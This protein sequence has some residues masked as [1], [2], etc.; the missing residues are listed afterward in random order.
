MVMGSMKTTQS[1]DTRA[2]SEQVLLGLLRR[3]SPAEKLS[4]VRSL[5]QMV[6]G[7]SRRAISRAN[8]DK[9]PAELDLLFIRLH[10]GEQLARRVGEYLRKKGGA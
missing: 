4:Q 6:I 5:S 2:D 8:K 7:L 9:D 3:K 1:P 10:Y